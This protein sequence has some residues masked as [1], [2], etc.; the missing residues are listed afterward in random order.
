[1]LGL[2]RDDIIIKRRLAQKMQFLAE[3][4]GAAHQPTTAEL[5]AWYAKNS[6]RFGLPSRSASAIS[7]S[8]L[9]AAARGS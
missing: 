3:D 5:K 6:A 8:R 2:D 4:V 1:M 9:T 7:T